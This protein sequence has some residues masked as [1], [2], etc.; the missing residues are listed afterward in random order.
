MI[1]LSIICIIISIPK[2]SSMYI[3]WIHLHSIA[4]KP[5]KGAA[6]QLWPTAALRI[7]APDKSSTVTLQIQRENMREHL[8]TLRLH[9]S[10]FQN[11]RTSKHLTPCISHA[12]LMNTSNSQSSPSP[13]MFAFASGQLDPAL[14]KRLRSTPL[15]LHEPRTT[16]AKTRFRMISGWRLGAFLRTHEV[17]R[18]FGSRRQRPPKPGTRH[19]DLKWPN[20][21]NPRC[22]R[23]HRIS[24]F[25]GFST[26]S[27]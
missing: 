20:A 26:Y 6:R 4:S 1:W 10:L 13:E 5:R 7:S 12:Q 14:R 18:R 15:A 8:R 27:L 21:S 22:N 17:P 25:F 19:Q 2:R 9:F 23:Y 3:P 24:I 16:M 11:V